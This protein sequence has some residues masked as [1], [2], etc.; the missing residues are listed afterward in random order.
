M[1]G[2][3]VNM[4]N[5]KAS[6]T[7]SFNNWYDVLYTFNNRNRKLFIEICS[8]TSPIK[9]HPLAGNASE[10]LEIAGALDSNTF[11]TTYAPKLLELFNNTINISSVREYADTFL[12]NNLFLYLVYYNLINLGQCNIPVHKHY[13]ASTTQ[14]NKTDFETKYS[15][16]TDIIDDKFKSLFELKKGQIRDINKILK[17][18]KKILGFLNTLLS[19]YGLE[20][21]AVRKSCYNNNN[22]QKF[23]VITYKL[24][25]IKLIK[26]IP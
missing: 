18:N 13:K 8:A 6:I 3:V 9:L 21:K 10:Y 4:N 15:K 17:T 19:N 20:L 5:M 11:N 16:I 24:D 7:S 25:I 22:K 26:E 23:K 12:R 2:N 1:R 14:I